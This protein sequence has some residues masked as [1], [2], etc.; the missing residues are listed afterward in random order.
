VTSD[1]LG[2]FYA[3]FYQAKK[4]VKKIEYTTFKPLKFDQQV[5]LATAKNNIPYFLVD[6]DGGV[7]LSVVGPT[8]LRIY[9]RANFVPSMKGNAK[10]SL[11][12]FEKGKEAASF[13]GVAKLANDLSFKE[14]GDVMPSKL[15]TFTFDVPA[16]KH[17]YEIK[18]INSA[19]PN[20]AVR[21]KIKKLGLGM[22]R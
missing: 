14:I 11:G 15:H 19:S 4:K 2:T 17:V 5:T 9:C 1:N 6:N 7:S 16:G 10:F 12:L 13:A 3:R 21:F 18:K 22:V 20:L 8:K